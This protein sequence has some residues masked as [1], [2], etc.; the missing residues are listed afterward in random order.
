MGGDERE[1][2]DRNRSMRPK[3]KERELEE[4]YN[5]DEEDEALDNIADV[6]VHKPDRQVREEWDVSHIFWFYTAQLVVCLIRVSIS[7][8]IAV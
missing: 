5:G 8:P 2:R 3:P 6:L 7:H 1:E 4:E